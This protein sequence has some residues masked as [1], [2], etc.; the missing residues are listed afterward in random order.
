MTL[1]VT[2]TKLQRAES[3][4]RTV[5]MFKGKARAPQFALSGV[6][7]CFSGRILCGH[8]GEKNPCR[9]QQWSARHYVQTVS[10][11]A[12]REYFLETVSYC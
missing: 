3:R 4:Y 10:Y 2:V 1:A 6:D 7:S 9:Y 12:H 11:Q 8:L 5:L